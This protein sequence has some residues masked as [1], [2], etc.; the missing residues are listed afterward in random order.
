MNVLN[1][2]VAGAI[3]L[4]LCVGVLFALIGIPYFVF[5]TAW[6][7]LVFLYHQHFIVF[8]VVVFPVFLLA[9]KTWEWLSRKSGR[10]F[11]RIGKVLDQLER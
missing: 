9:I 10:L 4:F 1:I 5:T 2:V 3:K 11:M 6:D 7:F 8:L